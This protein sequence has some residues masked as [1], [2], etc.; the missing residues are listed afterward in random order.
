MSCSKDANTTS[1]SAPARSASVAVWS[2]CVSWSTA[3]PS[4]MSASERNISSARSATRPWWAYVSLPMTAHCS[5][6]DSSI[7]VNVVAM[8]DRLPR[9][10]LRDAEEQRGAVVVEVA[11]GRT[12]VERRAQLLVRDRGAEPV[13]RERAGVAAFVERRD[14]EIRVAEHAVAGR[15]AVGCP[16]TAVAVTQLAR[17]VEVL[18]PQLRRARRLSGVGV[19]QLVQQRGCVVDPRRECA[20][21]L[22][23]DVE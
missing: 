23:V 4:V 9:R 6:V 1:S 8:A 22:G 19:L 13:H 20:R 3:K 2:E 21:G 18:G 14:V 11:A 15:R 7:R 5:A 10:R 16:R 12:R 17:E